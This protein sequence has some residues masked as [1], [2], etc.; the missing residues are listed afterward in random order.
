MLFFVVG[1]MKTCGNFAEM[2]RPE[3][4]LKMFIRFILSKSAIDLSEMLASAEISAEELL[5]QPTQNTPERLTNVRKALAQWQ[6]KSQEPEIVLAKA[7][8]KHGQQQLASTY[9]RTHNHQIR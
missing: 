3:I 5:N 4:A 9:L 8:P 6:K 7:E 1:V 2:K